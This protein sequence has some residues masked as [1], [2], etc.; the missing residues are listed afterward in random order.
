V[1]DISR[2]IERVFREE[3]GRVLSI[4]IGALGDFDL[5]ED[6]LQETFVAALEWWPRDGAPDNPAAWM[7]T[8]GLRKAI[9]R[10]R[11]EKILGEKIALLSGPAAQPF[12]DPEDMDETAF[13]DE[14]LKLIFTCC[15]P[16]LSPE[17]RVAL[18][19]RT[20]GG[21][22]TAEIA[23]AFLVPIPTM[24][25]RLTR[26]KA[27]I[28]AAGI[29]YDVPPV[30]AISERLHGV[31]AVLYLIFNEGYA[32]TSGDDLIRRELCA[33]AI[34]LATALVEL[35]ASR[36]DLGPQPEA[37]G[38]LA[39]MLLHDSR[40]AARVD[41]AGEIVLLEDQDRGRWDRAEIDAGTA[42]LERALVFHRPGPYQL[43]AAIAALHAAAATAA[44]TDW[45]QIAALYGELLRRAPSPV[46]KLNWAVA[47]GMAR[48]PL[49]GLAML[50]TEALAEA[51]DGYHWYHAAAADFLR[52][53]GYREA[54]RAAYVR[55]L[56]LCENRAERSFLARRI[57][58]L[59]P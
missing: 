53:A 25:Q 33:E 4:L 30:R 1:S 15:H 38:L 48:G 39:L 8:V 45:S 26:A 57:A 52:R 32:A 20:L 37:M 43:Q 21:L 13:P 22:D 55:A 47:A 17:A 46:V 2:A 7:V 36:P 40:R 35:L 9:D 49:A 44:E 42:L 56:A 58:E 23:R 29:P 24:N 31:L 19:L 34:R 10:L 41:A 11:R 59:S 18:T 5:A 50:Q 12:G 3:R 14:R 27:K 16:A 54:A 28:R 51:L 6:A